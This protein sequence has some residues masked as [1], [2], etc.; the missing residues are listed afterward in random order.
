MKLY[1]VELKR[2]LTSKMVRILILSCFIIT[3]LLS[4]FPIFYIEYTYLANTGTEITVNGINA[5]SMRKDN[6]KEYTGSISPEKIA[7]ALSQYQGSMKQYGEDGIFT[8]KMPRSEYS[9]KIEP[10]YRWIYRLREVYASPQTGIAPDILNL[11]EDNALNFYNQCYQRLDTLMDMEQGEHPSAQEQAKSL[12]KNVGMPFTYYPGI[13]GAVLDYLALLIFILVIVGVVIVAPVFSGEY[14]SGSDQILRCTKHGTNKLASAKIKAGLSIVILLYLICVA[15]FIL[16]ENSC[17]G[18]E[19]CKTSIQV[20][21]SATSFLP[22]N[23]GQMEVLVI[24]AGLLALIATTSCVLYLSS[25]LS[26][27]YITTAIAL[28]I[29]FSPM[30]FTMI[31]SGNFGMWIRCILPT[32]GVGLSNSILYELTDTNF[33]YAGSLSIW[34]PFALLIANIMETPMFVGLAHYSYRS[35]KTN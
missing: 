27:A 20:A 2:Q 21:F 14:Q 6:W 26:S 11:S 24:F 10:I 17:F 32:G 35:H 5:I 12:Y 1:L 25:R 30:F 34:L 22:I 16:I 29:C 13:D 31:I 9:Q 23:I 19:S 28:L 18:W 8:G 3:L 7:S 4:Y 33:I 15:V